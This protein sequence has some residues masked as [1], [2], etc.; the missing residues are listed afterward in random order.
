TGQFDVT[1][2]NLNLSV[3]NVR[4]STL[5]TVLDVIVGLPE[6]IRNPTAAVGNLLG[7]LAG[8][9]A[10][11][12]GWVDELTKAPID[13]ITVH[14]TAGNGKADLKEAVVQSATFLA[15]AHGTLDFAPELTNSALNI[16]VAVSLQRPLAEKVGLVPSGTPTNAVYVKLPD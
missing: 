1:S 6:M 3:V 7:R 2:T 13:T 4:S 9:P 5:K 11:H 12:R 8:V 10:E 14:G 15:Q 16:P